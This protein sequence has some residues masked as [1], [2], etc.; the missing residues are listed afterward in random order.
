MN[1]CLDG[2]MLHIRSI[3]FCEYLYITSDAINGLTMQRARA[4]MSYLSD[5]GTKCV[6]MCILHAH[7]NW[8]K[9]KNKEKEMQHQT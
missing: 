3:Q 7:K 9:E 8:R 2:F 4:D 1:E 5:S 6:V